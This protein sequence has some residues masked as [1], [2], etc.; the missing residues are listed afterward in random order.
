MF[1]RLFQIAFLTGIA[2]VFTLIVLKFLSKNTSASTLTSIGEIDSIFQ[3]LISIL[4]FGLQLSTVRHIALEKNWKTFYYQ[5]QKA[6][7]A[8]GLLITALVLL[9]P[10]Y[11]S[12]WFFIFAPVFALSGDYALYGRGQPVKAAVWAFFRTFIPSLLLI[13]LVYI[14][15]NYL[16]AVYVSSTVA[17]FGLTG[18]AISRQLQCKY[19]VSPV[20]S[21]L[22]LYLQNV[23]LGIA[24]VVM[25]ILG[26]GLMFVA[27]FFYNEQVLAVSYL[28]LKLYVIF[29]GIMRIINQSFIKEM[30]HD[31]MTLRADE[32]SIL[33]GSA[34][35]GA[36]VIFPK[37]MITIFF[38]IQ[39]T[40]FTGFI[41]LLGLSALA[42]CVFMSFHTRSLFKK[43]DKIYAKYAAVA[44]IVSIITVIALSFFRQSPINIGL[45]L[46]AGELLFAAGLVYINKDTAILLRVKFLLTSLLCLL[47]P[48]FIR[49]LTGD[50]FAGLYTGMAMLGGLYIAINYRKL[51]KANLSLK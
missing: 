15:K 46:F 39:Y 43:K 6:R 32:L 11:P 51:F 17:V 13:V 47:L 28:G 27:S 8:L 42:M 48:L 33:V 2:H 40:A 26:L 20:L 1:K 29:K 9:T 30:I 23:S 31:E 25:Y 18:F 24:T 22:K 5:A 14:N 44:A 3:L 4:G 36:S 21:E 19:L 10:V 12:C 49:Y 37:S 16:S 50:T 45:G 7:V 34:F 35:F 41:T 38:G